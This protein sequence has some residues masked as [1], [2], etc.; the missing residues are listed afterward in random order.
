ML[1][2]KFKVA[3]I[4]NL[5]PCK[6]QSYGDHW[7]D[8]FQQIGAEVTRFNYEDIPRL[9]LHY[10][11]YFFVEVRYDPATIPWFVNPRV[12]Y[13]W[14]SHVLGV[15]YFM[16]IAGCFDY[17][18]LASKID[19]DQLNIRGKKNVIWTPEG[20]N[21]NIHKNLGTERIY[22]VGSI[23]N[24]NHYV[25]R[26][27]KSKDDFTAFLKET[28][29]DRFLYTKG[30]YGED[31]SKTQNQIKIM[32]DRT[33]MHNVGTRIFESAAAGCVPL[34]SDAKLNTGIDTLFREGEHY[35]AYDD[36]M[37][38]L[39]QK[40]DDLLKDPERMKGITDKAKAHVLDRHTYAHRALQI[41]QTLGYS[42]L[43]SLTPLTKD[44]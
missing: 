39:H 40:I 24:N 7:P 44:I 33:I 12:L 29:G 31:Y 34:W 43:L 41:V 6:Y 10:D 38:D 16:P 17:I 5:L 11:L 15:D 20:C 14:D 13:S 28:Y 42:D 9:P 3:L 8:A 32:F 26:N 2:R 35:I 1:L 21:P 37:E 4:Y 25:I 19:V 36:T 22:D 18:C 27:G 23:A 30:I